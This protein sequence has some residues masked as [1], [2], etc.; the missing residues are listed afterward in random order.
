[1]VLLFIP[2][3]IDMLFPLWDPM[4]QCLHDKVSRTIVIQAGAP[5]HPGSA[6][7]LAASS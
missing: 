7:P 4:R 5:W 3:V 6:N 2:W 1:M